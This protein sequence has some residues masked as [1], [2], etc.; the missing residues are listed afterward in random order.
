MM[1][2]LPTSFILCVLVH[3]VNID[4]ST[5]WVVV[6]GSFPYPGPWGVMREETSFLSFKGLVVKDDF[7][8]TLFISMF[9][10]SL[11]QQK[12]FVLSTQILTNSNTEL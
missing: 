6:S 12:S 7:S 3:N 10:M 4:L 11:S 9:K 8:D 1:N 5:A 2:L